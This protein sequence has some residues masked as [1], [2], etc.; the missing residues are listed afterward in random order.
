[1]LPLLLRKLDKVD[2]F[3]IDGNH[4]KTPSLNYFNQ[5]LQHIHND[6]V[7][8][9][10][11]LHGSKEMHEVWNEIKNHP[12]VTLTI[13]LFNLGLVFYKEELTKEDFILRY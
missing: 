8:I 7:L 2:L 9:F 11:N 6:S 12:S 4:R 13:D 3:F 5:C 10:C 1:M